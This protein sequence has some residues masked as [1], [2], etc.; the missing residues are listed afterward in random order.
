MPKNT[1][2][3]IQKHIA[4]IGEEIG[5]ISKLEYQFSLGRDHLYSPIY[6]VVWFM[7]LSSFVKGEIVE[8]YLGQGNVWNEYVRHVPVAVFE[9]EGSTTSSKNQ[10][11][12]FANAYLS[13]AFFNIIV[14]NNAGAG[15]ERDTYR[16]GVKIYRSFTTL[17]GNR[18]AIFTDYEFLKNIKVNQKSIVSPTVSKQQNMRRKGSGGETS[19]V[20][21]ADRIIHDFRSSC[22]LLRQDYEPDQFYWHYSIDQA[23]QSVMC[24]PELDILMH[25]QVIWDPIT[26]EKRMARRAEDL[27]YIPKIDLV[28]GVMLPFA[29]TTFLR[30]LAVSMGDD[31][32]HY[33]ILAY[34]RQN[35]K[36]LEPLFFPV[37]GFEIETS[38]S[39]HLSGGII[40]LSSNTFCGVVVSPRV[41][42]RHV[43]TYKELFGVRNVFHKSSEEVLE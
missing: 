28:Y 20:E 2:V 32:W 33:P 1:T 30:N 43:K 12:N 42:S 8:K 15:T 35:T 34:M 21:L 36:P 25:K 19:S 10:V 17:L 27:Y 4:K 24:L 22:F 9:I 13:P 14:V 23:R 6:D 16:R 11:G 29:F 7:D 39:K 3:E 18:N 40:N 26:K 31:A 5:F 41:S 38:V 37:I